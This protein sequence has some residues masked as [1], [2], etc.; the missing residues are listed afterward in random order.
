MQFNAQVMSLR[1]AGQIIEGF[2]LGDSVPGTEGFVDCPPFLLFSVFP[3]ALPRK[4]SAHFSYDF[5]PLY[6]FGL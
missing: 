5:N 6:S 4:L 3:A 1:Y 2:N